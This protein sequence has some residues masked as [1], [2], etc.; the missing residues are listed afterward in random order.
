MA[1]R[2]IQKRVLVPLT[3]TFLVLI[4]SF[5]YSGYQIRQFDAKASLEYRHQAARSLYQTL[6]DQR[7]ESMRGAA[8][9]IA[10]DQNL[11]RAMRAGDTDALMEL[12]V[13]IL[14]RMSLQQ[15][16]PLMYFHTVDG[17]NLLRVHRPFPFPHS[18][19]RFTI[20]QAMETQRLSQGVELGPLGNF[21][22]RVVYPWHSRGELI[23][24][25]ELAQDVNRILK[26][27][28]DITDIEYILTIQKDLLDR[29][30]WEAGRKS[31]GLDSD[32]YKLRETVVIDQSIEIENFNMHRVTFS[33]KDVDTRISFGGRHFRAKNFPLLDAGGKTIGSFILLQ[34]VTEDIDAFGTFT[35]KIVAFSL[36]LCSAL[37]VFAF[38]ILGRVD[39]QMAST[40]QQLLDQVDRATMA[41]Y[42]LEIE[43]SER[44]I[45]EEK[46]RRLNEN[47]EER[48]AERTRRLEEVNRE[49]ES[50]HHKLELAYRE[51]QDKQATILHQDKM[52]CIGLLA[53]GVAHD[54]NNPIGFVSSNLSE[55]AEYV[56]RLV[57]FIQEQEE[58]LR[59]AG[60]E[61]DQ[62]NLRRQELQLDFMLEDIDALIEE[63]L[64]GTER[65]SNIVQNLR[66]F[67]RIDDSEAKITDLHECLDSTI[68]ITSHELRYKATVVRDYGDIPPIL[69]RP[70]QLNQVF[71]NLLINA[72]QAIE[73][74][75]TVTVR[76][77]TEGGFVHISIADTG[78]G[79]KEDVRKKIF[80][81]FFTTKEVG[82]GT[83]LGLSIAYDIV[84]KHQGDIWVESTL[85]QGTTFTLKL[86]VGT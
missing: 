78:C 25:I 9:F 82:K 65:V 44:K 10:A 55:L 79:I 40:R 3:L 37:F 19:D 49:L 62:L 75:G 34:D 46:L 41:N 16:I 81:P 64:E 36:L 6:V 48:V 2:N 80:E 72:A 54:I 17:K 23:G 47:L 26:N 32:W 42:R 56:P 13:P 12:A 84:K 51:L 57:R 53:A 8:Q 38:Q 66:T 29:E 11:Q 7:L 18:M 35:F 61:T 45:A 28:R 39:Q 69:C 71:M 77:W 43:V 30:K 33:R 31:L 60:A 85:G 68:N 21:T 15:D 58:A 22:L 74:Q 14:R 52:A 1:L 70:Q 67:S 73:E 24:F 86:P 59:A 20:R 83:G 5:L 76:T 27:L 4:I 50:S 63:S